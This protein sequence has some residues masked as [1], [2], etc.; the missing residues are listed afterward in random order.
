MKMFRLTLAL[1]AAYDLD[2][3]HADVTNAFFNSQLDEDV[4]EAPR[5]FH[6]AGEM[7]EAS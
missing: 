2:T 1:T 7:H 5:W 6:T 4:L 3:W